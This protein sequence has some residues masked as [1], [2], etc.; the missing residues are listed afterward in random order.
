[1]TAMQATVQD[2]GGWLGDRYSKRWIAAGCMLAHAIA[3]LLLA[4]ATTFRMVLAFAMLHGLA[5]GLRGPLMA[6]IRADYFGSLSFGTITGISSLI[7]MVGMLAGPLVAGVLA[8]RTG[9]YVPGFSVLAAVAAV[10]S[11]FFVMAR[12]PKLPRETVPV[13]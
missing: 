11:V 3:L 9:C 6:A 5:W 10:G 13:Q 8:D 7:A 1:M 4:T 2:G 12:P